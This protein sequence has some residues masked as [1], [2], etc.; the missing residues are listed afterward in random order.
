[1]RKKLVGEVISQK[2]QKI[3]TVL[4][5][6]KRHH[7]LYRK[8]MR[9][10]KKYHVRNLP[11][12]GLGDEVV[13]QECRPLAKTVCWEVVEILNKKKVEKLK[14]AKKI[15]KAKPVKKTKKTSAKGLDQRSIVL[16]SRSSSGR[17]TN[18]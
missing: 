12:A 8:V 14:P 11:G 1:M 18:N 9:I 2:M 10:R 4:V 17:K 16:G 6:R 15:K 3:A 7:P 5:E 13:I